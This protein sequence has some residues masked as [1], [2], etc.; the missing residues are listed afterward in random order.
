MISKGKR[1]RIAYNLTIDGKLIKSISAT[2]PLRYV[3]GKKEISTGLENAL[4]GLKVGDRK[5]FVLSTK[6]GYGLENHKSFMEMPK[7]MFLKKD[8]FIGR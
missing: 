4:R 1:V 5:Q 6:D 3:H 8:H 2:K 7:S